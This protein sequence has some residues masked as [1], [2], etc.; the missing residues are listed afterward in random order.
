MTRRSPLLLACVLGLALL[1]GAPAAADEEVPTAVIPVKIVAGKLIVSCDLSTRFRRIPV[2]LFVE[3]ESKCGLRL[4]NRAAQGIRAENRDGTPNAITIH[5]PDR[6]IT[7]PKREHGPEKTYEDFTKFHAPEI[8]EVA[9]VGTI[10]SEILR[11]WH[12]EFD[13]HEGVM[14]LRAAAE[15]DEAAAADVEGAVTTPITLTNDLVWFTVQFADGAPGAMALGTSRYDSLIDAAVARRHGKPAGDVG[16]L[17]VADLDLAAYVAFRPEDVAQVHEDGV[18]GVTGLNLLRSFKVEIDRVNRFIRLT[19]RSEPEFPAADL[20]F[21]RARAEE[22][23]D[24]LEG[25]L[26][27]H[28]EARLGEEA[29]ALLVD[30]RLDEDADAQA[31]GRALGWVRDTQPEDLRAT[32]LLDLM[33][34]LAEAGRPTYAVEAGKLGVESG[35]KDRYPD[36]VHKIHG[37]MGE[38]LLEAGER[39]EAWRHL[40]SAAFGLPEDGMVNL[41]LGRFYERQGRL[42][43]AFSRY[44]QACIQPESG[45]QALEGLERLTAKMP[46]EERFSVD[47]VERLVGGKVLSFGAATKF[48]PDE[49]NSTNRVVLAEFFTNAHLEAAIGGALGNEGILSHFPRSKLA[50]LAYHLPAPQMEPLVNDL[51]VRTAMQRGVPLDRPVV[52]I[53]DGT[54]QAPGAARADQKEAVYNELRRAI[55]ERL[56]VPSSHEL[57]L[58]LKVEGERVS[59]QVHVKGPATAGLKLHVVLAER[60]VL[61][62]G[63]SKVVIHRMLARAAL[64]AA[65]G[66]PLTFEGEEATVPFEATL[67]GITA[68]TEAFLARL[69][70]EGRGAAGRMSTRIDPDQI[71]VVAFLR[72]AGGAVV[73]A[74]QVDA[75]AS[76]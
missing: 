37:R 66:V 46:G 36:A 69:A 25:F 56:L 61:F 15:R 41:N 32:A 67:S 2:T 40:L 55:L 27:A 38:I 12:L 53:L 49:K 45:P 18:V 29:A 20:A 62:P 30:R 73:Q 19:K 4:H 5:L 21:F 34:K 10:G 51:A 17:R 11:A 48:E 47:L 8:G 65:E 1:R 76:E 14:R 63:K 13:L 6:A 60:G 75:K 74:V 50:V 26:K 58:D 68:E 59:G 44:V 24:A 72:D 31:M 71:T 22:D 43:R 16:P 23:A 64:V 70:A 28:P 9:L 35:R 52:H 7:V 54:V 33:Q 42:R 3:L 57:G 39:R